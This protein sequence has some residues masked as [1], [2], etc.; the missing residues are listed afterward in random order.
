[1]TRKPQLELLGQER[2][3]FMMRYF[4]VLHTLFLLPLCVVVVGCSHNTTVPTPQPPSPSPLAN[5]SFLCTLS[6]TTTGPNQAIGG[7][8]IGQI[9]TCTLKAGSAVMNATLTSSNTWLQMLTGNLGLPSTSNSITL[10]PGA[11]AVYQI[12]AIGYIM[13]LGP[14]TATIT[15][16]APGYISASQSLTIT[17]TS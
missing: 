5:A 12:F 4:R 8:G 6:T 9:G 15:I 2:T 10:Q 13:Q 14:N 17:R 7:G 1:M 16:T 3:L 11:S